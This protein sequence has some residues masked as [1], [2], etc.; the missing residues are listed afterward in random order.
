MAPGFSVVLNGTIVLQPYSGGAGDGQDAFRASSLELDGQLADV[1]YPGGVGDGQD[2]VRTAPISLDG[3]T[4]A[5]MFAG[6]DGDGSDGY[7]VLSL[8]LDGMVLDSI[9]GGGNGDGSDGYHTSL[10]LLD[11]IQVNGVF[12][13]GGGDGFDV[14]LYSG[15]LGICV[16]F[17]ANDDG[18]GSLRFVIGC[19]MA[20][21]SVR[22]D[23]SVDTLLI[24]LD[25]AI[26]IDKE[27]IILPG[28][29]QQII[30]DGTGLGYTI[31][32]A[33]TTMV[34][35]GNLEVTGS[36]SPEGVIWNEGELTLNGIV[37][38]GDGSPGQ[39][40]SNT[41]ALFLKNGSANSLNGN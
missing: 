27:I 2:A 12:A 19:T 4:S 35:L 11:G 14:S 41:G 20:G 9:F 7:P 1:M 31:R 16:V 24:A 10:I 15:S 22:F 38:H 30:V 28:T 40:L 23:S 21:D 39:I 29:G 13:G 5:D 37:L 32:I 3:T 17:N 18:P 36:N 6:G 33:S 26:D 8:L 34:E 25:S